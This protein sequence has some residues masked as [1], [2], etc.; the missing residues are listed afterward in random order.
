MHYAVT[1][2]MKAAL[3][4]SKANPINDIENVKVWANILQHTKSKFISK[5]FQYHGYYFVH[6][7]VRFFSLAS[8]FGF[9]Y[10]LMS[11]LFTIDL[12]FQ[13]YTVI[14]RES[15]VILGSALKTQDKVSSQY[16][17]PS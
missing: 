11:M 10:F 5:L 15:Q 17:L 13:K 7:F 1:K 8:P 6:C 14:C 12:N 4:S 2:A 9:Y 16:S 3:A